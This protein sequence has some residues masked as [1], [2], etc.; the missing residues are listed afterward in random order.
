VIKQ[1]SSRGITMRLSLR[2]IAFATIAITSLSAFAGAAAPPAGDPTATRPS[3]TTSG[4]SATRHHAGAHHDMV[5]NVEQRIADLHA[6][7]QITTAQQPQWDQFIQVMR[8]N[9]Q[10]M[11]QTFQHRVQTMPAMT[12]TENMQSYA[13]LASTNAQDVQKL[14]PAFQALYDTMS[15]TQKRTA[16]QVFRDDAHHGG[17]AQHS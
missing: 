16:D 13:Q 5:D 17:H 1:R 15:D 2:Q 9:A 10:S 6:K 4:P 3:T 7:L 14:V 12:A 11:D 8:D